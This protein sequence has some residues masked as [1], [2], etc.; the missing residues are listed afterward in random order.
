MMKFTPCALR[1]MP[2]A[3]MLLDFDCLLLTAYRLLLTPFLNEKYH[4]TFH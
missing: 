2:Y 4:K 1:R 3:T